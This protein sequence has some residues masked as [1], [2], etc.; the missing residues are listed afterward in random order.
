MQLSNTQFDFSL[1]MLYSGHKRVSS[2]WNFKDVISP[3]YRL[4]YIES[5][6]GR[7]TVNDKIYELSP[8]ELFLIPK[9]TYHSYECDNYMDH[10]YICFFDDNT[11]NSTILDPIHFCLQVNADHIDYELVKQYLELNPH[12]SLPA[13][14]PIQYDNSKNLYEKKRNQNLTQIAAKIQSQ[15]ILLYLFSKFLTD[16]A[17]NKAHN[18]NANN[19]LDRVIQYINTNLHQKITIPELSDIICVSPDH[20]SKTFKR[21]IGLT[22]CDYIQMKRI[23]RAQALLLTSQK[24]IMEIAESI[25][26]NNP[27]QFTRLFTKRVHCTPRDYRAKQL[28]SL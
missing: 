5:G 11:S 19:Q 16:D 2:W 1:S 14:N 4:Y 24:S 9:F 13:V 10:F 22:P 23:E 25:G 7:V 20:F 12:S 26:I 17:P 28:N 8:G 21:I 27:A 6:S 18:R 15:G 3:F